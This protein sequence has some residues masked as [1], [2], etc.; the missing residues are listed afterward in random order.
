VAVTTTAELHRNSS[1]RKLESGGMR[2]Y[3]GGRKRNREA[4]ERGSRKVR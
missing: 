4:E 1:E 3:R 2:R